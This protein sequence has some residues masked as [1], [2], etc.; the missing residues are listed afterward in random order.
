VHSGGPWQRTRHSRPR[1]ACCPIAR[2]S[3]SPH[4][5]RGMRGWP[6]GRCRCRRRARRRPIRACAS[7]ATRSRHTSRVPSPRCQPRRRGRAPRLCRG[8][9]LRQGPRRRRRGGHARSDR[10]YGRASRTVTAQPDLESASAAARPAAP[11]PMTQ[12]VGAAGLPW[13]TPCSP[14]LGLTAG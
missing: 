9:T 2:R 8:K 10:R 13:P 3:L 1:I 4:T 6:L 12:H 11:G 5:A 7:R 14:A